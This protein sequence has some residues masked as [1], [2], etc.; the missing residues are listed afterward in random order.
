MRN[1]EMDGTSCNEA[2][3]LKFSCLIP[4]EL[5]SPAPYYWRHFIHECVMKFTSVRGVNGK[6]ELNFRW[7]F[8][9]T[10]IPSGSTQGC[11]QLPRKEMPA[12][13][14]LPWGFEPLLWLAGADTSNWEQMFGWLASA[15]SIPLSEEPEVPCSQ[16]APLSKLMAWLNISP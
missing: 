3:L 4:G 14:T 12:S 9:Q 13:E 5:R 2:L 1:K 7:Y 8:T 10:C 15:W 16:N 6:V 11:L